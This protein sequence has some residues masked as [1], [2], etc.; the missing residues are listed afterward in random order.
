LV[1]FFWIKKVPSEL[2]TGSDGAGVNAG[3]SGL[4]FLASLIVIAE[5]V[6]P[7]GTFNK[8]FVAAEIL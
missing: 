5:V 3:A 6:V 4:F 1:E 2:E 7:F 8:E